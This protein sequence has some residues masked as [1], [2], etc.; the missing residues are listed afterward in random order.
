M[1]KIVVSKDGTG[2]YKTIN[3]AIKHASENCTIYI[4][5]GIYNEKLIIR[6]KLTFIG[7]K[8]NMPIVQTALGTLCTIIT[9]SDFSNIHFRNSSKFHFD[10]KETTVLVYSNSTFHNCTFSDS[11]NSNVLITGENR[12]PI[13]YDCH[14]RN[15]KGHYNTS[16][17]HGG[18]PTYKGCMMEN[19]EFGATISSGSKSTFIDC[20][21]KSCKYGIFTMD[22]GITEVKNC[23]IHQLENT[24]II[25]NHGK[26]EITDTEISNCAK[27]SIAACNN[28]E[29]CIKNCT[30]FSSYSG[31]VGAEE[32]KYTT[33]G[34]KIYDCE[35]GIAHKDYSKGYYNNCTLEGFRNSGVLID[36][37]ADILIEN[38]N[39]NSTYNTCISTFENS[40]LH[41]KNCE[42]TKAV[43]AA[44]TSENGE[45]TIEN[46]KIHTTKNLGIFIA[47]NKLTIKNTEISNTEKSALSIYDCENPL[48]ENVTI[49]DNKEIGLNLLH[50]TS[51]FFKNMNIYNNQI[52]IKNELSDDPNIPDETLK[53]NTTPIVSLK[54]I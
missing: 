13:F 2:D 35:I 51:P 53:N 17:C 43:N 29:I 14:F 41:L 26:S 40:K 24:G 52:G 10:N 32:S 31:L 1:E 20:E 15:P 47:Q 33:T 21:I 46:C 25:V 3:K 36:N 11:Y 34:T 28:S 23:K 37:Y 45:T 49:K 6:K 12:S 19:A 27:D 4:K 39:I 5:P 50:V 54:S 42:V 8:E 48:L 9:D 44:I 16:A 38:T 22:N 18:S 30:I 7:D